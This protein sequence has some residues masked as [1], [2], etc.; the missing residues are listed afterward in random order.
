METH[1][2]IERQPFRRPYPALADAQPDLDRQC[3]TSVSTFQLNPADRMREWPKII[4]RLLCSSEGHA[5][6]ETAISLEQIGSGFSGQADCLKFDDMRLLKLSASG[7]RL[8]IQ[9]N[10][11]G[12]LAS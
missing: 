8:T 6:S 7:H 12:T 5:E 11:T 3:M 1:N 4:G 2:A 9:P 10:L